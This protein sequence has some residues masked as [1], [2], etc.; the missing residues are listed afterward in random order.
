MSRTAI[1]PLP[2]AQAALLVR[3][4]QPL[5]DAYPAATAS[6]RPFVREFIKAVHSA[7]GRTFS[8][9]I[10]RK[11]LQVHAPGRNPSTDTLAAEKK[12]FVQALAS[13]AQAGRQI[14][15]GAG[16]GIAE[17][18]QRAVDS[19]L[20]RQGR[21]QPPAASHDRIAH[22]QL[23]FLQTRLGEAERLLAETRAQAAR[24]AGELLAA[25]AVRDTLAAQVDAGAQLAR[26]H[27][28]QIER[29]LGEINGLRNF[30]MAAIDA[31]R[32]E[33]RAQ[34]ERATH[35]ESLLKT[36]KSHTEVFRRLA[37]R[38]GAAIPEGLLQEDK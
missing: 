22:A 25:Q 31:A 35:L 24:L 29:L 32:G 3:A 38:N 27:R 14:E 10:Y 23:D 6:Q 4:L 1:L 19:A 33:T 16:S 15:E 5:L 26:E 20:A 7:T 21:V 13:E 11:L 18:V 28:Q 34:K 9:P 37:Y 8:P 2:D 36:E 12:A 17:V 30:A